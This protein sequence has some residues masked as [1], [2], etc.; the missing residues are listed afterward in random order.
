MIKSILLLLVLC[1]CTSIPDKQLDQFHF[2]FKLLES[3]DKNM[4]KKRFG[5][6]SRTKNDKDGILEYYE[7]ENHNQHSF[8][9]YWDIHHKKIKSI[10][11][12]LWNDFDNYEYLKKKLGK[13]NWIE[14][15][16]KLHNRDHYIGDI[17]EVKIPEIRATFEYQA[18]AP[19]RKI[20]YVYFGD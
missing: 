10:Q 7:D 19:N 17:R 15:K 18:D 9:I 20:L 2:S 12:F 16:K 5:N 8:R 6:F 14:K 3:S 11:V 13:Y 4:L 1:S